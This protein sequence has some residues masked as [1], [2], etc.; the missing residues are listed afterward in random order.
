MRAPV[1]H[2]TGGLPSKTRRALRVE[3]LILAIAINAGC[4]IAAPNEAA[5]YQRA[6]ARIRALEDY[7]M[8]KN[9]CRASGGVFVINGSWGRLRKPPTEMDLRMA[10][11]VRSVPR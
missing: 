1:Q 10:T 4:A 9:A 11:C 7:D 5:E 2:E 6:D 3:T 8:R